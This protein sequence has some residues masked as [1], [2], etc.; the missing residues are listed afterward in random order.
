M[1]DPL[2]VAASV[3]GLLALGLQSTEYLINFY[4]TY[5]DRD[6]DLAE[7]Q[8]K[9]GDL[10]SILTTVEHIVQQRKWKA[11]EQKL[12]RNFEMVL[13]QCDDAIN[14]LRDEMKKREE[15]MKKETRMVKALDELKA[16]ITSLGNTLRM[17][18]PKS[19]PG[20]EPLPPLSLSSN[21]GAKSWWT[22]KVT[23]PTCSRSTGPIRST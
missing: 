2:S 9:L 1:A 22:T 17:L 15:K 11:D 20:R 4:K 10:L 3:A 19:R 6:A 7:I 18:E 12:L 8:T 13:S 23:S 14:E 21:T 16:S 5:K